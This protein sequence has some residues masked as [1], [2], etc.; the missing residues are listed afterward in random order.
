MKKKNI[1]SLYEAKPSGMTRRRGDG[2]RANVVGVVANDEG[3]R[4][5]RV[6]KGLNMNNRG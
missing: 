2:V 3:E 4:C 5:R 6:L 1:L